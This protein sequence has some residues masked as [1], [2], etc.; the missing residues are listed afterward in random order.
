MNLFDIQKQKGKSG[1]KAI[2]D[3]YNKKGVNIIDVT[4][5]KEYQKNDIDFIFNGQ[6]V[7]IKTANYLNNNDNNIILEI[8]SNDNKEDFKKG[9]LYTSKAD[10]IIFYN[11][12]ESITY[13][14][15]LKDLKDYYEK[16]KSIIDIKYFNS[17]EYDNYKYIKCSKLAYI[18]LKNLIDN[19]KNRIVYID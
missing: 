9:W 14:F 5:D 6:T 4:E 3:F 19:I 17:K 18:P 12:Q 1:E 15:F 13:Q 7:E 11:P 16:N 10:V 2:K 8:I